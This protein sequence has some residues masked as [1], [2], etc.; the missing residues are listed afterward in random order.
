MSNR[1]AILFNY[2]F[3]TVVYIIFAIGKHEVIFIIGE[4]IP[5]I[6]QC[7]KCYPGSKQWCKVGGIEISHD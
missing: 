7:E 5:I 6:I 3:S 4:R 1:I 2:L